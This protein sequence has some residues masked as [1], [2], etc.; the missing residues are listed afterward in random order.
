MDMGLLLAMLF[1]VIMVATTV[2]AHYEGLRL[3]TDKLLPRLQRR[4]RQQMIFAIFA[5][6]LAHTVEVWLFTFAY[7]IAL[8]VPELG[9]FRGDI[10]GG[11]IDL[12]YFS[13]ITYTSLGLG[14]VYPLGG[15][16]LLTA[17]EALVGLLMIGWSASYT[18]LLMERLWRLHKP[19]GTR[20]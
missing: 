13:A 19:S 12:M 15:L 17:V 4:P 9:T 7:A 8:Q 20:S 5:V 2:M 11:L 3:I 6:F 16:R 1:C 18:Y 10:D 14:D